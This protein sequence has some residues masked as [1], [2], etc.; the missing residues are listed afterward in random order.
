MN[1]LTNIYNA[2]KNDLEKIEKTTL[3]N[4]SRIVELD[5]KSTFI[6]IL[7]RQNVKSM[8][9]KIEE[10]IN[11]EVK[12]LPQWNGM[13]YRISDIEDEEI[14]GFSKFIVFSQTKDDVNNIFEIIMY[15]LLKS[16]KS[17]KN[18]SYIDK[19]IENVL[20]KWK[21][22]FSKQ[23]NVC[24]SSIRQQ[25]LY[26]E[27]LIL[28]DLI[29]LY[30]NQALYYW[31]G[32]D[33]ETH[34]FYIKNNGLEVKTSSKKSA[35]EVTINSEYQLDDSDVKGNLFL[36]F[37][38]LKKSKKDGE[39]IS[40]L[41]YKIESMLENEIDVDKFKDSL[42]KYGYLYD[43]P[44]LYENKFSVREKLFYK[45][46]DSFPRVLKK[47]LPKGISSINYNLDLNS[48]EKFMLYEDEVYLEIGE[49]INVES[50]ERI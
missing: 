38:V 18:T 12:N 42:F 1:Y 41:I 45:V 2:I 46:E 34:D 17:L 48:C 30:G 16:I 11:I 33:N 9:I 49:N 7:D 32:Y 15:D 37:I 13:N 8:G 10:N 19:T 4:L 39:K 24:M 25:G 21:K 22:F 5:N 47:D 40:E 31:S 23:P 20:Y 3:N 14:D 27:L 35:S 50:D 44:E 26:G 28:K 43:Y 29:T 36:A 6:F